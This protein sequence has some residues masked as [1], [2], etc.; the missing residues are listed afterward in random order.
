M[1]NR[2]AVTPE[3]KDMTLRSRAL[4]LPV[5]GFRVSI[6]TPMAMITSPS[7]SLRTVGEP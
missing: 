4:G 1:P 2:P 5:P 6:S 7:S 3:R